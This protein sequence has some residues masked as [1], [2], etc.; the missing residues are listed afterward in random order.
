MSKTATVFM[1]DAQD[2]FD[3]YK[4][5]DKENSR[6][7]TAEDDL[8][9]AQENYNEAVRKLEEIRVNVY[10]AHSAHFSLA[11]EREAKHQFE[12]SVDGVN[13]ISLRLPGPSRKCPGTGR[14]GG[15]R[16]RLAL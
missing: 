9:R 6:R 4:D 14:S 13:P 11:A 2:E 7:K 15:R 12:L 3:K 5:L 8:E 1:Q 16:A 10:R